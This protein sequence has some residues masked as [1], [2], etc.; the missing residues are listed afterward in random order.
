MM[1]YDT[2]ATAAG[3]A[4]AP[5]GSSSY[6]PIQSTDSLWIKALHVKNLAHRMIACLEPGHL[7]LGVGLVQGF[8]FPIYRLSVRK[9]LVVLLVYL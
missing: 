1:S 6:F 8:P 5:L 9:R 7:E 3:S 4:A 2:A